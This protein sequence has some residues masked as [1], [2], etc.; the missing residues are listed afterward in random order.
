MSFE[1][2]MNYNLLIEKQGGLYILPMFISFLP[3]MTFA[4][5]YAKYLYDLYCMSLIQNNDQKDD[6][7]ERGDDDED[8]DDERDEDE[9]QQDEEDEEVYIL[10]WISPTKI[11]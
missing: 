8:D 5:L 9:K 10:R 4:D 7:D 6:D 11:R 3:P 1:I 2:S